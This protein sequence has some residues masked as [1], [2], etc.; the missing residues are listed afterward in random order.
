MFEGRPT[1]DRSQSWVP[2]S[3]SSSLSV[4]QSLMEDKNS[5]E[6]MQS[7]LPETGGIPLEPP[8]PQP[9]SRSFSSPSTSDSELRKRRLEMLASLNTFDSNSSTLE[10]KAP[11]LP[12]PSDKEDRRKTAGETDEIQ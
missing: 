4:F 8:H 12:N 6:A 5:E 9:L 1:L 2:P 7:P 11:L 3:T 10:D